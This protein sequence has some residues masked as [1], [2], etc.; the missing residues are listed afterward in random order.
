M[1]ISSI[2]TSNFRLDGTKFGVI[3]FACIDINSKEEILFIIKKLF[4]HT[5]RISEENSK[6]NNT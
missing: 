6:E 1:F 5:W 2:I 4:N 3:H